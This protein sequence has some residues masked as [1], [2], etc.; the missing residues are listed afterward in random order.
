MPWRNAILML[1]ALAIDPTNDRPLARYEFTQTEMGMPFKLVLY[2]P[3][4]DSAN[5]AAHAAFARIHELNEIFSD[6]EADSELARLCQTA[7]TGQAVPVSAD[8]FAI[9]QLSQRL[10]EQ[11]AGAFDVTVGPCV[12]LWRKAR[13]AKQLPSED[14]LNRA[15]A[16]VDFRRVRLD[17][18]GRTVTLEARG[19]QLDLGGIA[20]G[21]AIDQALR[22]LA[23]RGI[24]RALIDGSGDIGASDPPPDANGWK[25]A[26]APLEPDAPPS[27]NIW[28]RNAAVT[29]S[30][31]AFQ[32]VEIDGQR[33]SH[34]VDPKTGLGLTRRTS[35][36]VIAPD[37]VTADSYATAV[38]IMGPMA[39]LALIE[40][41]PLAA[42]IFLESDN[43]HAVTHES[44]RFASFENEPAAS[45]PRFEEHLIA[46]RY[47][48]AYGLAAADLDGDGH[49]DLTS[50]DISGKPPHSTL[51]WYRNDGFG[52]FERHIIHQQEPGWFERHAVADLNADGRPDVAIVNNRDGQLLWFANPK[53][54]PTGAWRRHVVSTDAPRAYDVALADLDG[55][56]DADAAVSGYAS[57]L[58]LWFKNPGAKGHA[59]PWPRAV[60]DQKMPE[61]RTIRAGDFNGDG[62]PDLL[63]AS[64]GAENVPADVLDVSHHGSSIVWYEN[65]GEGQADWTKRVIDAQSRAPI[66]GQP[67]DLDGDGDLDV[68]MALGMRAAL[69][70]A[71]K[72]EVAWFENLGRPGKGG[73]WKKHHIAPLPYAFEA[74]SGDLDGDGD[75]D[76]AATAWAMGD[77]LVWFENSAGPGA[78][79]GPWKMHLVRTNWPAANQVIIADFDGDGRPD[80]AA[81]ADDGSSRVA[82]ARE[83]RWWRNGR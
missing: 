66:H 51:Y 21:Y 19:M 35:V 78:A 28:I 5:G 41:T 71:E 59:S 37:C 6:Y 4:D 27:R 62:R 55:D 68:V 13:R 44:R 49:L 76:V 52:H 77:R 39:G 42:A 47:G 64:V 32:F 30:G 24:N 63:A 67:V 8:L 81:T 83:L 38:C 48:Y 16:L 14:Q 53:E 72:H 46:D 82:G 12:R 11:S 75:I 60:I 58:I 33:Y 80:L 61:A 22:V 31:D 9:L 23:E 10:S 7:G 79:A 1:L 69:A 2:A 18:K 17:Q 25:I 29:T 70:P 65:P 36:T 45:L 3:D 20:V 57:G 73:E 26:I 40:Q 74:V 50:A 43:G 15:K 56:G 54:A 34:I